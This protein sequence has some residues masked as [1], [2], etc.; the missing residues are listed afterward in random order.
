MSYRPK[1]IVNVAF[2]AAA[3]DALSDVEWTAL[4]EVADLR[5]KSPSRQRNLDIYQP[6]QATVVIKDADRTFDQANR[7]SPYYG[8]LLPNKPL[9]I[10]V[11]YEH[12]I[13]SHG[14]TSYWRLG[15]NAATGTAVDEMGTNDGTYT[16]T[17]TS[18][19]G[20]L[21]G[22]TNRAIDVANTTAGSTGAHYVNVPDSD[23]LTTA[24]MSIELWV[25]TDDTTFAGFASKH[26]EWLLGVYFGFWFF[27][28]FNTSGASHKQAVASPASPSGTHHLVATW[29][30]S[31]GRIEI[32]VDGVVAHSHTT[33]GT[34]TRATN[35]TTP[36]RIGGTNSSLALNG[37]V[38]EVAYYARVLTAE[39]ILEHYQEGSE[40]V[41]EANLFTGHVDEWPQ[42]YSSDE[43]ATISLPATDASKILATKKLPSSAWEAEIRQ[44]SPT[45]WYRLGDTNG[46][47]TDSSGNGHHGLW[48]GEVTTTDGLLTYDD[49]KATNFDGYGNFGWYQDSRGAVLEDNIWKNYT[50]EFWCQSDTAVLGEFFYQAVQPGSDG[51][52]VYHILGILTWFDQFSDGTTAYGL[53]AQN[54]IGDG[55]PHHV[56]LVHTVNDAGTSY[57]RTWYLDGQDVTAD[58]TTVTEWDQ[59]QPLIGTRV[60]GSNAN[61][62]IDEVLVYRGQALSAA[63]VTA[64]YEAGTTPWQGENAGTRA[65]T[66]LEFAGWSNNQSLDVGVSDVDYGMPDGKT[67]KSLLDE[68]AQTELGSIYVDPDGNVKLRDRRALYQD[69]RHIEPQALYTDVT[70]ASGVTCTGSASAI[71]SPCTGTGGG[72]LVIG[73]NSY[74]YLADTANLSP[75]GDMQ[76]MARVAPDDWSSAPT[77]GAADANW[78]SVCNK[79]DFPA[80][81][82]GNSTLAFSLD[83]SGEGLRFIW[84]ED[85]TYANSYTATS[86]PLPCLLSNGQPV[87][88]RALYNAQRGLGPRV[89]FY[90]SCEETNEREAVTWVWYDTWVGENE[91]VTGTINIY[92]STAALSWGDNHNHF[93]ETGILLAGTVGKNHLFH[94]EVY[95]DLDFTAQSIGAT[96]LATITGTPTHS[97]TVSGSAEVR[98]WVDVRHSFDYLVK[99][100]AT[101]YTPASADYLGMKYV[102]GGN[103]SWR[104]Q[105]QTDGTLRL[106]ISEDGTTDINITSSVALSSVVSNGADV[107]VRV[108]HLGDVNG[109]GRETRFFYSLS[110]T[111]NASNVQWTQLGSTQSDATARVLFPTSTADVEL[112]DSFTGTIYAAELFDVALSQMIASPC[113]VAYPGSYTNTTVYDPQDNLWTLNSTSFAQGSGLPYDRIKVGTDDNEIYN[114]VRIKREDGAEQVASDAASISTYGERSFTR[115]GLIH[116]DD[117]VSLDA[118]NWILSLKKDPLTRVQSLT[119]L[120]LSDNGNY[121]LL[122]RQLEDLIR[123]I[124]HPQASGEP[125]VV[126]CYI[127]SIDHRISPKGGWAVDLTLEPVHPYRRLT[128]LGD[129]THGQ[130]GTGD[131][132]L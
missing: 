37:R 75:T 58:E 28:I 78:L 55:L 23:S 112:G 38:D 97:Y 2:D 32:Y 65:A 93:T 48:L 111:D 74:A 30:D 16:G 7:S 45:M 22:S 95:S 13:K 60:G 49:Q 115:T 61:G 54:F 50:I 44:D 131:I 67:A 46:M 76:V 51:I 119:V 114:E 5:I 69:T 80:T 82:A 87:W 72:G 116:V 126:D 43:V 18:T 117:S 25:S 100:N 123:V 9:R 41:A 92:D 21:S 77:T 64:H 63:R 40:G 34:G 101:D 102:A 125:V 52:Y 73:P 11:G 89:N 129:A 104:L 86:M 122:N 106:N 84:S 57:D 107:W 121:D 15:E 4:E 42:D 10:S 36:L 120:L 14:P 90:Y 3:S 113:F 12:L 62:T 56:V 70:P 108:L 99:I 88:I 20:L 118:A 71:S 27:Q 105:L 17:C 53:P 103:Q 83:V 68:L 81:G 29:K 98:S 110:T 19:T 47:L 24:D 85:G 96:A 1:P 35:Q 33:A 127:Q 66:I 130:L 26:N 59:L 8:K 39:E 94:D 132:G 79:G 31:T 91:G 128:I 124:R 6:G 109:A